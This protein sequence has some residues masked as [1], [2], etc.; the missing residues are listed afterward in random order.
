MTNMPRFQVAG[1]GRG[2]RRGYRSVVIFIRHHPLPTHHASLITH[3][4]L[5]SERFID[6]KKGCRLEALDQQGHWFPGTVIDTNYDAGSSRR[7]SVQ[8][9]K[10]HLNVPLLPAAFRLT[11]RTLRTT[12]ASVVVA[13][14]VAVARADESAMRRAPTQVQKTTSTLQVPTAGMKRVIVPMP[15][16]MEK[17]RQTRRAIGQ[18][19]SMHPRIRAGENKDWILLKLSLNH[20]PRPP[21]HSQ[22]QQKQRPSPFRSISL[23]VGRVVRSRQVEGGG[24]YP[25]IVLPVFPT[26]RLHSAL[27]L[28]PCTLALTLSPCIQFVHS[29]PLLQPTSPSPPSPSSSRRCCPYRWCIGGCAGRQRPAMEP[30]R[31]ASQPGLSIR[32]RRKARKTVPATT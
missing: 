3:H 10:S 11:H 30:T 27:R 12:T 17:S 25:G 6:L 19:P 21:A 4:S 28:S 32:R 18:H 14:E 26:Q 13:G 24:A 23:E 15:T 20:F 7:R 8:A 22:Q 16:L 5:F 31:P 9:A 2:G 1:W 29:L